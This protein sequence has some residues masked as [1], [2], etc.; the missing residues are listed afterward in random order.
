MQFY[1]WK[2]YLSFVPL[3]KVFNIMSRLDSIEKKW[4]QGI[5]IDYELVKINV[6]TSHSFYKISILE[7]FDKL[8]FINLN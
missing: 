6:Q 8:Y 7:E 5:I 1:L 2:G 3:I 4:R